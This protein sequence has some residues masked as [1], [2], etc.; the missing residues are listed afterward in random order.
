V[1]FSLDVDDSTI[2]NQR[3]LLLDLDDQIVVSCNYN[4]AN[5]KLSIQPQNVLVSGRN[6]QVTILGKKDGIKFI[7]GVHLQDSHFFEFK[8]ESSLFVKAPEFVSPNHD[9]VIENQPISFS[10]TKVED[11]EYY[12][13]ELSK[14]NTFQVLEWPELE[15]KIYPGAPANVTVVPDLTFEEDKRYY[16][17]VRAFNDQDKPGDYSKTLQF[18]FKTKVL[19]PPATPAEEPFVPVASSPENGKLNVVTQNL[20]RISFSSSLAIHPDDIK[21][22]YLIEER[23]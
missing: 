16:A 11:A 4:Y 19:P 17:R 5:K 15:E 18:M 8:T 14:T 20:T 12:H 2:D 22:V 10:F 3:V 13:L 1:L 6:Y 9:V 7:S 23:N 21:N